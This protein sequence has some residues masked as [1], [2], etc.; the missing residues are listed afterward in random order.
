MHKESLDG[1]LDELQSRIEDDTARLYGP[2][3]CAIWKNPP[4]FGA[5]D[6]PSS[7]AELTG[8]CGDSMRIDLRIK[9]DHVVEARYFTTGCGPSI[10][11]GSR[12][13]TLAQGKSLEQAA[14]MEDQDI[15]DV[16][17]SIP[18]DKKHCAHLAAQTVREA[19]RRYWRNRP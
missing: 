9:D 10:I 3:A 17:D 2:R 12:A 6:S 13:C 14:A 18:E 15:L 8:S 5:M 19:I 16:F 7:S 4:H 11:S 1:F